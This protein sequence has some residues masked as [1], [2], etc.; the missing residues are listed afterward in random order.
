MKSGLYIFLSLMIFSILISCSA[1]QTAAPPPEKPSLPEKETIAQPVLKGWEVEWGKTLAAARKEGKLQLF[2]WYIADLGNPV[3]KILKDKF[4]IQVEWLAMRGSEMAEKVQRERKAGLFLSDMTLHGTGTG[5]NIIKPAGITTSVEPELLLP[6]VL[7][8]KLWVGGRLPFM[9]KD[10]HFIYFRAS[11]DPILAINT[12]LVKKEEIASYRDLLNP[13]WKGK[14]V[15]D[16]PTVGG[17]GSMAFRVMAF[18]TMSLDFLREMVKQ[19]LIITRD[20]RLAVDWISKGRYSIGIGLDTQV[21][22]TFKNAGAP[23]LMFD[24]RE[25]GHITSGGGNLYI[26]KDAPNPNARRL[27]INWFL[28]REGQT[29]FSQAVMEQSAREDI[30]INHLEPWMVRQ[31]GLTYF[32]AIEEEWQSAQGKHLLVAKEVFAP[33]LK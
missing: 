2:S 20:R 15:F 9:D 16:D 25:G 4:G 31:P 23:V 24:A 27:F 11:P 6:E 7:D 19:D 10:H 1:P 8:P 13:K 14:I 17:P 26:F 28:S 33:L 29:V 30:P 18:Q 5:L 12:E 32:N 22:R 3:S 21:L